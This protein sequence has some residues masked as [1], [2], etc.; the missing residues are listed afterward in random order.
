[1]GLCGFFTSIMGQK[2]FH[3]TVVSGGG[4]VSYFGVLSTT[5]KKLRKKLAGNGS[6]PPLA[7][8]G[9]GVLYETSTSTVLLPYTAFFLILT[10]RMC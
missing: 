1:M 6:I 4:V 8:M 5:P 2:L 9:S 10:R 7:L 3:S